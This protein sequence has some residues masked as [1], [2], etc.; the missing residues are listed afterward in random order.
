MLTTGFF[1]PG[2]LLTQ[3]FAGSEGEF[4]IPF[5]AESA[6][7]R[8]FEEFECAYPFCASHDFGALADFPAMIVYGGESV[9]FFQADGV[10]GAAD[11][12]EEVFFAG[13]HCLFEGAE[14][15][16]V[17][18]EGGEDA[19]GAVHELRDEVAF[20]VDVADT[21]FE[22][23]SGGFFR[24]IWDDAREELPQAFGLFREEGR[25]GVAFDAAFAEAVVEIAVEEIF[26]EVEGYDCI[27]TYL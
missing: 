2:F 18:V 1:I 27:F 5:L 14:A 22:R 10:E 6:G 17:G 15:Y 4:V 19:V 3:I 11:G 21:L 12:F 9:V 25:A 24:E 8:A 16:A 7:Q 13:S 23:R 20:L 26:Y